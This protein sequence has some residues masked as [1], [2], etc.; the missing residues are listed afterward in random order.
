M[1][2]VAGAEAVV[3]DMAADLST[4]F[5]SAFCAV[6]IEEGYDFEAR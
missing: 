3:E 1:G 5:P 2:K 4:S 6:D